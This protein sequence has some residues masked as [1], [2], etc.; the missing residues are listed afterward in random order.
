MPNTITP[1]Y[2]TEKA[3]NPNVALQRYMNKKNNH[4][5]FC[6]VEGINDSDYYLDK[7]RVLYGDDYFFIDCHGKEGVLYLYSEKYEIDH[8]RVKMAF[9]IDKDY[10]LPINNKNIYETECYSIENYYCTESSF[11]RIL[12]CE[13]KIM[14]SEDVEKAVEYYKSCYMD[15]HNTTSLFNAFISTIRRKKKSLEKPIQIY[16]DNQF[17]SDLAKIKLNGS[18]KKYTYESL[19]E[20]YQID[21]QIISKDDVSSEEERLWKGNPVY[22]FRGK[23]EIW[24]LCIMLK[25][26][27]GNAGNHN[28]NCVINQKIHS[29][30]FENR[31]MAN[32][33][34]CADIPE[35]LRR[36]I[37]G[38]CDN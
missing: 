27:I 1:N 35:S 5:L 13:F 32:L 17:P 8:N 20:K 24:F 12:Q 18:E 23:Y 33:S 11:R 7:I 36:Y 31:V 28:G 15:F 3:K 14:A 19:I 4:T 16:L 29:N 37:K 30:I 6:F 22:T 21:S 25:N 10:D 9:F 38:F 2:L 34:R 26:L